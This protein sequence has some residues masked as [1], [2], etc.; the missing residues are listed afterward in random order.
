LKKILK[1]LDRRRFA[2]SPKLPRIHKQTDSRDK[3][4]DSRSNRATNLGVAERRCP[5]REKRRIRE[6]PMTPQRVKA[7]LS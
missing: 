3:R 1:M 4:T 2:I 7:S 5:Y 6:L